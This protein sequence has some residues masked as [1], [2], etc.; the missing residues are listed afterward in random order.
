MRI[1][2]VSFQAFGPFPGTHTIDI[3]AVGEGGL[4]LIQ[5][6]TGTG[7]SMILD[8][9][10]FGLYNDLANPDSAGS[11][12]IESR[13]RSQYAD[14]ATPT[15]VQV[16]FSVPA[17]IFRVTRRPGYW[18]PKSRGQGHTKQAPHA[19]LER[20]HTPDA[21]KGHPI[22]VKAR[23]VGQ[24]LSHL[25]PL[26]ADQFRQTVILPQGAFSEFLRADTETREKLLQNVFG[27]HLFRRFQDLAEERAREARRAQ[28]SYDQAVR[29][30]AALLLER[31]HDGGLALVTP[32]ELAQTPVEDVAALLAAGPG[33]LASRAAA[34]TQVAA[35]A[36]G[37][38]RD[39]QAALAEVDRLAAAQKQAAQ[40]REQVALLEQQREQ[41]SA[42]TARLRA[43]EQAAHLAIRLEVAQQALHDVQVLQAEGT[44]QRDALARFPATGLEQHRQRVSADPEAGEEAWTH[45]AKAAT[46]EAARLERC[47]QALADRQRLGET[48][49][50][51]ALALEAARQREA[52]AAQRLTLE[53]AAEQDAATCVAAGRQARADLDGLAD[54]RAAA[55]H[56]LDV[57]AQLD[58]AHT[59]RDE[60]ASTA[61]AAQA[62]F[63][64]A[65]QAY[66]RVHD[67]WVGVSAAE[68]AHLLDPG[69]P[70]PV[71]GSRDHPDRAQPT[72]QHATLNQVKKALDARGTA[73]AAST[74]AAD[75]LAAAEQQVAHLTEALGGESAQAVR[76]RADALA[77]QVDDLEQRIYQG[78]QAERQRET[79]R[80]AIA[81]LDTQVHASQT[82]QA[83]LSERHQGI[84]QRLAELEDATRDLPADAATFQQQVADLAEAAAAAATTAR[85]LQAARQT[86]Q[87][88]D[89][90]AGEALAASPFADADAVRAATLTDSERE[91]LSQ[92]VERWS[93]ELAT[94][95]GRLADPF[96][97]AATGRVLPDPLALGRTVAALE[98]RA[99]ACEEQATTLGHAA[100]HA[101]SAWARLADALKDREAAC[102]NQQALVRIASLATGGLENLT[103]TP[104]ATWVLQARLDDVLAVANPRLATITGGRYELVRGSEDGSRRRN[105]ALTIDV[106]DHH[107]EGDQQRQ[108]ATLSGGETFYCSLSLALALAEIVTA[109]AGGVE[110]GTMFVD[111]GFGTLDAETLS[112]VLDQLRQTS[113][114]RTIGIITH[115]G[116]VRHY[117]ANRIEVHRVK[118]A[119][120]STLQIRA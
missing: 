88:R 54:A 24:E 113:N 10:F 8:A 74:A 70:C 14:P 118:N 79:H 105:Q 97:Q 59:R 15:Q 120:H 85:L 33:E 44:R 29:G 55:R 30:A 83:T 100:T 61:E 117:I 2:R 81:E 6:A 80:Q 73:Q 86:A 32:T 101:A 43:A 31:L 82:E 65:D 1:H 87:A 115:V 60:A 64:R 5:G 58:Q 48:A 76:E 72:D 12:A 45:L 84:Q 46:A 36:R 96:L 78:T 102:A 38:V 13:L 16:T 75:A 111:E 106:I 49:A 77:R 92:A 9:I 52:D 41:M 3:D 37:D 56:Q 110:I 119:T 47:C 25:L 53:R 71:C 89:R 39:A 99:S 51:L 4:F 28:E 19:F 98:R 22:A 57:L 66:Q 104:L 103:S 112:R 90:E 26:S 93:T 40:I 62:A 18:R 35:A 116:E 34:S 21:A 23:E 91:A 42:H 68:L 109:E 108:V 94:A 95:R 67:R 7:K 20:L 107:S 27:T 63:A 50:D 69:K 11:K 17:G 114:E